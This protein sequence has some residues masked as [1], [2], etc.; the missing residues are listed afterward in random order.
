MSGDL[1]LPVML[2]TGILPGL[3][4]RRAPGPAWHPSSL[5]ALSQPGIWFDGSDNSVMWQDQYGTTPVTALGQSVGLVL[6]K[7]LWGGKTFAQVMAD[8]PELVTNGDFSAGIAGW[9]VSSPGNSSWD[10]GRL[11]V[12]TS[13]AGKWDY[14]FQ[15]I[16][17]VPGRLYRFT[18]TVEP[19][20][21]TSY[22]M[23]VGHSVQVG[24][25]AQYDN[26]SGTFTNFFYASTATAVVTL[27]NSDGVTG[28][29][30]FF[31]DVSIK[32]I[33]GNH[34]SQSTAASRP[35][36]QEDTFGARGLQFDGVN[37]FLVTQSIDF[38]G[39]D[40]MLAAAGVRKLSDVNIAILAELSATTNANDGTFFF[41]TP[42]S[43]GNPNYSFRSKGTVMQTAQYTDAAVAAPSSNVLVGLGDIA[44]DICRLRVDGGQVAENTG[45]Q[46]SGNFGHYPLYIGRREGASL[47]YSGFLPQ[48][49]IRGGA[50]PD[51][52]ELAQLEAYL[53]SKSGINL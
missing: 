31:D 9:D 32:E 1:S 52:A 22:R 25:Y 2:A 41:S 47:P 8:Q 12:T 46:G 28:S 29:T 23:R 53:A 27:Q 39:S 44:G 50:W 10:N 34:A 24:H 3:G 45:D 18:G 35:V 16:P 43:A 48:L 21:A 49:V 38:S 14:A 7:R 33:P 4:A 5:F 15:T 30:T 13:G 51:A 37:D 20:T 19:G 11:K 26:L 6:D 17:L 40:K 42:I 36:W